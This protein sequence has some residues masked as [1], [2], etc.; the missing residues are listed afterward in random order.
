MQFLEPAAWPLL[1]LVPAVALAFRAV[2]RARARRLAADLGPRA[3]R[4]TADFSPAR[5][6][7]RRAVF[8]AGLALAVVAF[9]SPVFGDAAGRRGIDMMVC[10]DVS[11][12]MLARDVAPSR[13]ER[14]R[15]EIRALAARA[16]GDRMGLV[17][18][19]GE[20]RLAVPLTSDLAAVA[21]MVDGVDPLSVAVG[22]TDLAAALLTALEGFVGPP[23]R[24]EAILL[25][26]DGDEFADGGRPA[27]ERCRERGVSVHCLALG[28]P[29]GAKVPVESAGGEAFLRDREGREVVSAMAPGRLKRIAEAAG[30]GFAEASGEAPALP[31]LFDDHVVPAARRAPAEPGTGESANRFQWPL[32]AAFVLWTVELCFSE[33]K[34][35]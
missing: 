1:L 23:G 6:T 4:L 31:G 24:S 35:R 5:R 9:L 11:R 10:L 20:A 17:V 28:S 19:A 2:H 30:G 12:S 14:A 26:T 13:L 22:G 25:L 29:R 21:R 3:A 16:A 32:L 33:R 27:A 18:F 7:L 34:K 8:A 15:R